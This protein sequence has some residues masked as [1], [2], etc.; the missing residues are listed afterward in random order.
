VRI[1]WSIGNTCNFNCSYCPDI[2]KSG[3]VPFLD[4]VKFAAAFKNVYD[5]FEVLEIEL[6]GGEPT[7]CPG[8]VSALSTITPS[9]TK[10]IKIQ[11]NGS[12]SLSWW[13]ENAHF[14]SQVII[15]HHREFSDILH[16]FAVANLLFKKQISVKVRLPILPDDWDETVITRDIFRSNNIHTEIMLL[17]KNFTAGN[18]IY[19]DYSLDQMNWYYNDKQVRTVREITKQIEYIKVH[20]LNTYFGHI[21]WAG[22]EQLVIDKFGYVF[23]GWCEQGGYL[24]NIIDDNVEWP[25]DP[26]LCHRELCTN[27]FDMLAKKS[28]NSWNL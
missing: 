12:P 23:R 22:V 3:S 26:I 8:L 17:Y 7:S 9:P 6:V 1:N 28:E 24:G 27:G 13:E 16:T 10:K 4:E 25:I 5:R 11:T 20:K 2:L 19:Y 15:S 18:N 21:C 14:F